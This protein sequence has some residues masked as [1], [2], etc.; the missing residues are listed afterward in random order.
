MYVI[1]A[2]LVG[3]NY[4]EEQTIAIINDSEKYAYVDIAVSHLC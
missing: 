3:S 4:E 2:V 1:S